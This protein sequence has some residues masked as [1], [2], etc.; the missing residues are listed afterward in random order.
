[1]VSFKMSADGH[2]T[3]ILVYTKTKRTQEKQNTEENH[4]T[5]FS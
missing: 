3:Y 4:K 5:Q 2:P 1:M